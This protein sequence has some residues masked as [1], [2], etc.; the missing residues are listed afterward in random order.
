MICYVDAP[1]NEQNNCGFSDNLT[2]LCSFC[3]AS[4][5]NATDSCCVFSDSTTRCHGVTLPIVASASSQLVTITQ[6]NRLSASATRTA[7]AGTSHGGPGHGAVTGIVVGSVLGA[8]FILDLIVAGSLLEAPRS[9]PTLGTVRARSRHA[10]WCA[11]AC[12]ST[13]DRALKAIRPR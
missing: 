3:A 1:E 10:R 12:P 5:P 2:G 13:G 11:S 7:A 6:T 9:L 4:S 8:L